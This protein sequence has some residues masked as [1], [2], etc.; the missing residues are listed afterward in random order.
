MAIAYDNASGGAT[1]GSAASLTYSFT[2]GT[3]T[4]GCL[5]VG[6]GYYQRTKSI[7]TV[8]YGGVSM[9]LY[10]RYEDGTRGATTEIWRL[11]NP[12]AGTANVVITPSASME[13]T[14]GAVTLSGVDQTTPIEANNGGKVTFGTHTTHTTNV[15]TATADAWLLEIFLKD[16]ATATPTSGQTSR[17]ENS[18]SG[19][20]YTSFMATRGPIATPAS[21]AANWS[22]GSVGSATNSI[23]VSVKP[24]AAAGASSPY[25]LSHYSRLVLGVVD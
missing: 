1:T 18:G 7:S 21:E 5:F 22:F 3:L 10:L 4:D 2:A 14:S 24:A 16:V 8:T 25:Y 6:V 15:T 11:L 9:T 23:V 19:P 13:M 20:A 17:T 12:A